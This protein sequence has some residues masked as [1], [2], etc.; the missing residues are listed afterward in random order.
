MRNPSI[1]CLIILVFGAAAL[2]A[3][4]S[5]QS[6]AD[7]I[8]EQSNRIHGGLALH[9]GC[10]GDGEFTALLKRTDQFIV[11]GVDRDRAN[12]SA[13]RKYLLEKN[14][15][16]DISVEHWSG[17]RLP[18]ANDLAALAVVEDNSVHLDEIMRV[19]RPLGIA[20]FRNGD[21]WEAVEKPWPDDIDEWTHFLH[22]AGNNAVAK[23]TRVGAPRHMQWQAGPLWLRS[24]E[25]PSG[26][27]ALITARSR[28]FYIL[29]RG[30]IGITDLRLPDRWSIVC[31]DA[32]SGIQLWERSLKDWGLTAFGKEHLAK[33]AE[34]GFEIT[35]G[36]RGS[37]P[38]SNQQRLV[39]EDDRLYATLG[40]H[41]APL[42]ILDAA[43]GD[44]LHTV[45]GTEGTERIFASNGHV[46]I[47]TDQATLEAAESGLQCIDGISGRRLWKTSPTGYKGLAMDD[48]QVYVLSSG[49]LP[50]G[51]RTT[52]ITALDLKTGSEQWTKNHE[53]LGTAS[54]LVV[55]DGIIT[56]QSGKNLLG[57]DAQT[58]EQLWATAVEIHHKKRDLFVSGGIVYP[59]V[60][61]AKGEDASFAHGY[62]LKTGE[63]VKEIRVQ[64]IRSTEHH[65]RCYRNKATSNFIITSSEGAEYF[66]LNGDDHSANN[67]VRG[68]CKLG[69]MPA[70][71]LLYV[72]AD[73]CFCAPGS[74]VLGFTAMA[75]DLKLPAVADEQRLIKGP[76]FSRLADLHETGSAEWPTFRQGAARH[77]STKSDLQAKIEPAWTAPL[78]ARLTAPVFAGGRLFVADRDRHQVLALNP[79][80]GEVEW[81]FTTGGPMDSPNARYLS[82][83]GLSVPL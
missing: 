24:H 56:A 72:P 50:S 26:I 13:A 35:K 48:R 3:A 71:G 64:S 59:S 51:K 41:A 75:A 21:D 31:R 18:Y 54:E 63:L 66:D 81:R 52:A 33:I 53:D 29:D 8:F 83:T 69:M 78:G 16:G 19:L 49:K 11:H 32:F 65:D 57:I 2:S 30:V 14:V 55:S 61:D 79:D 58:G 76:A 5:P 70:N 27:Q 10:G 42:V 38:D 77:G 7:A 20:F 17:D 67:F 40:Y 36:L 44:L 82:I 45:A 12:I 25:T 80:S 68:A 15:Y 4:A 9:I 22:D 47:E 23:D 43:T 6:D 46:V 37:F 28:V 60:A 34:G 39:A 1:F 74:K 62:D 73:Q